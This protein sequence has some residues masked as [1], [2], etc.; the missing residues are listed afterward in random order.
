M[1]S[2]PKILLPENRVIHSRN[3]TYT[4]VGETVAPEGAPQASERE[5]AADRILH[6]ELARGIDMPQ[7]PTDTIHVVARVRK[8]NM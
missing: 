5:A 4:L 1:V 7:S 8:G 3:V 2:T 6:E